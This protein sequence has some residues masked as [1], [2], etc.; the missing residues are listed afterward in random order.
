SYTWLVVRPVRFRF[1]L[2]SATGITQSA[3]AITAGTLGM[4]VTGAGDIDVN[5]SNAVGTLGAKTANGN[6][7]FNDAQALIVATVGAAGN[8]SSEERRLGKRG[9]SQ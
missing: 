4:N 2:T 9:R 8:F 5:L 6:I 3:G 7:K 1:Y